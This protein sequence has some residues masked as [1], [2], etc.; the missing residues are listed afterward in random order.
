MSFFER[1]RSKT[2]PDPGAKGKL[3]PV[4][5]QTYAVSSLASL[6]DEFPSLRK[7]ET[8]RW[9]ATL[10]T[11]ALFVA[12]S[13]LNH[14]PMSEQ[15]RDDILDLVTQEAVRLDAH[16]VEAVEDCR[17]F[18]DRTYDGLASNPSY[19]ADRKFLFS[20]SLGGWIVWNLVGHAPTTAE[21]CRMGRTL[22]AHAVHAFHFWWAA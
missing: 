21:E 15:A 17:A 7:I 5:A 20:H 18:V 8:K 6:L 4:A 2:K 10:T 1:F 19:A 11:A 9:D 13:R 16:A 12:V 3:L 14:T 22:G